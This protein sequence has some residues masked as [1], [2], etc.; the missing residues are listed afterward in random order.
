MTDTYLPA[1]GEYIEPEQLHI[2]KARDTASILQSGNLPFVR[3]IE[4]RS[5]GPTG[6]AEVIVFEVEVEVGQRKAHDIHR[7]ERIVVVFHSNDDVPPDTLVLRDD[8]PNVPHLNLRLQ[9]FPRSLCL[10]EERYSELKLR[11]TATEFLE[12]IREW[13]ALTARGKLHA[14]DQPLEPLLLGSLWPLVLPFE[15]FLKESAD[16]PEPMRIYAVSAGNDRRV[17]I[18][19][20]SENAEMPQAL[21]YVA[22]TFHGTSQPHGIIRKQ[23]STLRELCTFMETTE[24]DLLQQLRQRLLIWQRKPSHSFLDR[25][26]IVIL[27]LPKMRGTESTVEATDVWA[28]LCAKTVREIGEDLG[29]W[30]MHEGQLAL[31][32]KLAQEKQGDQVEIVVLNPTDVFSRDRAA[33]LSGLTSRESSNIT[34]IGVGY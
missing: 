15:Q 13:L 9:E 23:P 8:F 16:D 29:I 27:V 32:L 33:L 11:W 5:I 18:A 31:L 24:V 30:V 28:F 22:T 1:P 17:L 25:S 10:F 20:Q 12:R 7:Y 4:C 2:P 34:L 21:Q 26:L 6:D 19:D 14:D 3:F